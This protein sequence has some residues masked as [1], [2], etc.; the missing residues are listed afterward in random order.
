[1]PKNIVIMVLSGAYNLGD[2]KI[3]E[4][5]IDFFRQKFP[6]SQI[7]VATYDEN[8]FLWN[9]KNLKFFSYF[10]NNIK[11]KFFSNIF[12]FFQN[13]FEIIKSD[14]IIVGGGGI[15][16]DNEIGVSFQKIFLE[17]YIRLF[18][19][20]LFRK[21]IIFL[22]FSIEVKNPENLQILQKIFHKNDII[23]P[24]DDK[25]SEIIKTFGLKST[26]LYDSVFLFEWQNFSPQKSRKIWISL[27]GGFWNE[28]NIL[29]FQKFLDFLEKN[30]FEIIFMSHS[31][32]GDENHNDIVFVQKFFWKKYKITQNLSETVKNYDEICLMISMRLHS[33]ILSSQ[34]NI[35]TIVI[36]YW[37][38]N[39]E[40]VKILELQNNCIDLENLSFE[41]LKEKFNYLYDNYDNEQEKISAL[42]S[43]IHKKFLQ[44]INE[45]D[46]M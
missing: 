5:E 7:S 16:F 20:R 33:T 15:F 8:S 35:P 21:K 3:L 45:S 2:E 36:P 4:A 44:K 29:E 1:M 28:K 11:K 32:S 17:W 24:R 22:W 18:F 38:K 42:Y 12:Y 46:I 41:I 37:P 34:K 23:L 10:P 40:I 30:N 31:T 39:Y 25:T 9:K 14:L 19:A 43:K 26:T 13:I 27:R 6:N